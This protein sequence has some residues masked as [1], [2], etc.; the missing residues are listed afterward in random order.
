MNREV[1]GIQN[2]DI[3]VRGRRSPIIVID[4][5]SVKTC[6]LKTSPGV[7]VFF[8]YHSLVKWLFNNVYPPNKTN[9]LK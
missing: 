1:G 9:L 2:S 5:H 6:L 3:Y 4:C 8:L 7:C